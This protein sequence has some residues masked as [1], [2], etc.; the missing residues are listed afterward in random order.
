MSSVRMPARSKTQA[1]LG[2]LISVCEN[3]TVVITNGLRCSELP[4]RLP[5]LH[6]PIRDI[7][8]LSSGKHVISAIA[9]NRCYLKHN[10]PVCC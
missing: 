6:N 5:V 1:V 9:Y 10:S 2:V 8:T 3:I 7:L 4:W